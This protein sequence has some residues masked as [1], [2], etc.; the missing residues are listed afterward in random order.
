MR[1]ANEKPICEFCHSRCPLDCY[2][3]LICYECILKFLRALTEQID[4]SH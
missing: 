3:T 1:Y 2:G 4:E